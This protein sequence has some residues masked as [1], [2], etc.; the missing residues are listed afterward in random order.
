[1][2]AT[3]DQREG[4]SNFREIDANGN[5][6]TAPGPGSREFDDWGNP[7][8]EH[9][10]SGPAF[11]QRINPFVVI[12]WLLAALLLG[13]GLWFFMVSALGPGF[14]SGPIPQVTYMMMTF[15]PFATTAG[16]AVFAG[17]LFW[18]ASH[19]QR[20]RDALS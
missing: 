16:L 10:G 20:R 13:C 4:I 8:G 9:A 1:M 7:A 6:A 15:A 19:W 17:L 18:H 14:M 2:G 5:P 11:L 12:L 3:M